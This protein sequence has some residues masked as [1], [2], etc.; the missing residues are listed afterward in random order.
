M[1]RTVLMNAGPW[2]PV[3][4]GGYG[5]VENVVGGLVPELR[6]RGVRVLLCTVGASTLDADER[7]WLFREPMFQ[8]LATPYRYAMGVAHAHMQYVVGEL[9]R[10]PEIDLIHDHLEVVGPSMLSMLGPDCPPTLQ[11]LHWDLRLH[12]DFYATFD[13]GNR[14]FFNAVS[15]PH[16]ATAPPNLRRQI[17]GAVSLGVDMEA[18]TCER[19]KED[20]FLT[21]YRFTESKG[22][23]VAARVCQELGVP[24]RMAGPVAGLR[25]AEELEKT[26]ADPDSP[27][28]G[29]ADVQ[30]YLGSVRIYEDGDRIDWVGTVHGPAKQALLGRA[31][32]LLAPVRW[33][34]PGGT[35]MIEALACGTPV[36]GMRRGALTTIVEHGVNGF[37]CDDEAQLAAYMLRADEIDP[38][39]CRRV[40]EDR[41]SVPAMADAYL[42]LYDEVLTRAG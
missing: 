29:R 26:L 33:E 19:D 10:R 41:F 5:G 27:Y 7:L 15:E 8:H 20:Y 38:E 25:N 39:A 13:G 35:A 37:L 16:R 23:D 2:L 21:L 28:H 1:P 17:L 6:R 4:P 24:L 34:E 18:F 14:I 40:A 36:I 9:R 11:T 31:K 3:P 42:R 32:A 12:P 22:I 30:Y